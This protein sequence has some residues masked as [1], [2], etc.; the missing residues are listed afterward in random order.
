MKDQRKFW[1]PA[2]LILTFILAMTTG[3]NAADI[4]YMDP[5]YGDDIT[6][7][8]ND[9]AHPYRTLGYV[10]AFVKAGDT[11]ILADGLYDGDWYL[12]LYS[13]TEGNPVTV[14]AADGARPVLT[15][16]GKYDV[17]LTQWEARRTLVPPKRFS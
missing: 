1:K 9:I 11:V 16:V 10:D 17:P 13:G 14:R 4:W 8:K 3:A 2:L 5:L 12:P 6:G 15:G 7:V